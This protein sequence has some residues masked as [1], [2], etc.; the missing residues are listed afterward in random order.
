MWTHF[1]GALTLRSD[2]GRGRVA[3]VDGGYMSVYMG[4]VGRRWVPERVRLDTAATYM[5][6]ARITGGRR[7]RVGK[8]C[9]IA[10]ADDAPTCRQCLVHL[11]LAGGMLMFED[12]SPISNL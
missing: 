5:W 8:N 2:D 3:M 10:P 6:P 9:P 11:I 4:G 12:L 1:G 7:V